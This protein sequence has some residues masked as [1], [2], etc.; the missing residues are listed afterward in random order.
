MPK[1]WLL[2]LFS[3]LC[4]GFTA[5]PLAASDSAT[6]ISAT[7]ER[8]AE[9]AARRSGVPVSVLKAISLTETGK[10]IEGKLRPWP[11]TVNMEGAGHWFDTLDEARAYVFKEFKRGA[12]SFDVGCFQI[13]Y[14]WHNQHF[15]SIDEMFD[16]LSNALYAAKFLTELYNEKGSWNGAAGAYHSR[17]KEYADRYTARFAEL[18]QRFLA[19]DGAMEAVALNDVSLQQPLPQMQQPATGDIPEIPD[20]VAALNGPAAPQRPPRV[21]N[22]PLL[23]RSGTVSPPLGAAPGASLFAMSLNKGEGN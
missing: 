21:N 10:R 20:I 22:Y 13:N 23:Q 14:K 18:R 11:W 12:R 3:M 2:S 5:L 7:C 4:V 6:T 1:V 19:A 16:P 17:T 9:E 15:T 8:V